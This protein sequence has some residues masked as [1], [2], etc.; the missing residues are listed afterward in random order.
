MELKNIL[1]VLFIAVAVD[2]AIIQNYG[3]Y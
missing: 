2:G 3:D 1:V